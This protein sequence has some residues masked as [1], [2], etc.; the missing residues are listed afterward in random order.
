MNIR[1]WIYV[2]DHIDALIH[3]SK[4]GTI[5][6]SYCIG[7]GEE[8]EN[9]K[10]VKK[11]CQIYDKLNDN[12]GSERLIIYTEDRKGHD[13]RYSIDSK[14][15]IS[16]VGGFLD[17]KRYLSSGIILLYLK[18]KVLIK[19]LNLFTSPYFSLIGNRGNSQ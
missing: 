11:I 9:I 1:E 13:Y 5:G 3:L 17:C 18:G 10:I 15:L 8:L 19:V 16:T 7:S 6:E 12:K 2:D 4:N 14:K